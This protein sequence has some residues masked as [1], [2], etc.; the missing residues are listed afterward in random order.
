MSNY[1]LLMAMM[2]PPA[3]LEGEFNAWYDTEH[4]PERLSAPG[5]LGARRWVAND[6]PAG[7]LALYDLESPAALQSPEYLSMA[8]PNRTEWTARITSRV[9]DLQRNVYEQV[10]PGRAQARPNAQALLTVSIDPDPAHEAELNAWYEQEHLGLLLKVPG[11]LQARRFRAIEGGPKYLA[12][13]DL[14]SLDALQPSPQLD[15]ARNTAWAKR[16]RST[17]QR[18]VRASYI[19]YPPPGQSLA[20][21]HGEAFE[22]VDKGNIS[23]VED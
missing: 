2:T 16:I 13:Y 20:A 12:I 3:D 4:V 18:V 22:S 17:W 21:E 14:A 8:G 10:W 19:T 11:W 5:F 9:S 23:A 6:A 7:Y 15:A 1:G